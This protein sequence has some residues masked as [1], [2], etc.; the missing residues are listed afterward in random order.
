[1][2]MIIKYG[3]EKILVLTIGAILLCVFSG[4][5]PNNSTIMECRAVEEWQAKAMGASEWSQF[6]TEEI[7]TL[8]KVWGQVDDA[9]RAKYLTAGDASEL[10][11]VITALDGKAFVDSQLS[12]SLSLNKM[13]IIDFI[14]IRRICAILLGHIESQSAAHFLS[15]VKNLEQHMKKIAMV[16]D[17]LLMKSA[18]AS[19]VSKYQAILEG[20]KELAWM[21]SSQRVNELKSSTALLSLRE[22]FDSDKHCIT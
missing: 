21:L 16:G 15:D 14:R 7:E 11:E 22:Y 12:L 13:G 6:T 20:E 19:S 3:C 9:Y 8:L 4:C 5:A 18:G 1:M 10:R 17:V 2:E